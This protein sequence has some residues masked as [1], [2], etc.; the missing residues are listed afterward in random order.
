MDIAKLKTAFEKLE[1]LDPNDELAYEKS[2]LIFNSIGHLPVFIDTVKSGSKV[3]RTRTHDTSEYFTNI[4][5][6]AI[7]PRKFVKE[8]ARCNRPYQ[9]IFYCSE[10][11]PTSFMELLE[12]WAETKT[13]G[14]KLYITIGRWETTKPMN[15]IIVT[16]PDISKRESEFD[17]YHGYAYDEHLKNKSKEEQAFSAIF[18]EYLFEKFRKSAKHDP[19]TYIITATYCNLAL[20][21][22]KELADGITYPS[23]P[24]GNKGVNIAL[25]ENYAK[26]NLVLTHAMWT[27]FEITP[28]ENEKYNFTESKSN[29]TE[30][31][32][33]STNTIQW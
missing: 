33:M 32:D 9:S 21:H 3:L 29:L 14:D 5:D 22:A 26:D 6:I 16:S 24:F 27:E 18:F 31:I 7:T 13:F 2:F 23:V 4:S 17:K 19:K 25:K 11:R 20:T 1:S 12:Y 10:N 15:L 28:G 30:K 8:F